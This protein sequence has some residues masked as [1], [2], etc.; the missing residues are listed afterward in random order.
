MKGVS[1]FVV[2]EVML[3]E[4]EAQFVK[5]AELLVKGK[6]LCALLVVAG[7][8]FE[9]AEILFVMVE[10]LFVAAEELFVEAAFLFAKAEVLLV[11]AEALL[12]AAGVLLVEAGLI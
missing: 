5:A 1:L 6:V 9:W 2:A 11:R 7:M 4:P 3:V 12:L 8:H 10:A